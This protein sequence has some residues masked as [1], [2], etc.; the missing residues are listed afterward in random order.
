MDFNS[1]SNAK[2]FGAFMNPDDDIRRLAPVHSRIQFYERGIVL[3]AMLIP[4]FIAVLGVI[5]FERFRTGANDQV[6]ALN[7]ASSRLTTATEQLQAYLAWRNSLPC[8][9]LV[10]NGPAACPLSK[11]WFPATTV[12]GPGSTASSVPMRY[13]VD[14]TLAAPV[15]LVQLGTTTAVNRFDICRHLANDADRWIQPRSGGTLDPNAPSTLNISGSQVNIAFGLA[16]SPDVSAQFDG[17]NA[18]DSL[19]VESPYR[20]MS[21]TY[22]NMTKGVENRDLFQ[23]LGC[24]SS[25]ATASSS[26]LVISRGTMAADQKAGMKKG[27]KFFAP[28]FAL[29]ATASISQLASSA[30]SIANQVDVATQSAAYLAACLGFCPNFPIAIGMAATTV[31]ASV[32]NLVDDTLFAVHDVAYAAMGVGAFIATE[33]HPVWPDSLQAT[34]ERTS[35][36]LEHE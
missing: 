7:T 18:D 1:P 4:L 35:E 22:R 27:T 30:G 16:I 14:P 36:G 25:Q 11:G 19:Q 33:H 13:V 12:L 8:A 26:D 34:L 31:S 32:A 6:L 15:D 23:V 24:A 21:A 29:G 2:H 17:L 10:P 28:L 3:I 20:P 5:A 9:A